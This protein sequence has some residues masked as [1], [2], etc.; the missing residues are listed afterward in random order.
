MF[1]IRLLWFTT[2][3]LH[4]MELVWNVNARASC[5]ENENGVGVALQR[6]LRAEERQ[7]NNNENRAMLS[8]TNELTSREYYYFNLAIRFVHGE[9]TE[10]TDLWMARQPPYGMRTCSFRAKCAR[11]D[12]NIISMVFGVDGLVG[13]IF[14]ANAMIFHANKCSQRNND[15]L[16]AMG[17]RKRKQHFE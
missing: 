8:C 15:D 3:E 9:T 4:W 5:E 17:M 16:P 7:N 6:W 13:T 12:V 2:C 10:R 14:L 11:A 1:F